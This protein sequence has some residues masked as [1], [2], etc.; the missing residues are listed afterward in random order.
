M[1]FWKLSPFL[2]LGFLLMYQ[3]GIFQAAPIRPA[4]E[5]HEYHMSLSDEESDLLLAE[6]V[7]SYMKSVAIEQEK[8]TEDAGF[9]VLKRACNTA[10]CLTHKLAGLLSQTGSVANT[11]L[12]PPDMVAKRPGRKA[13]DLDA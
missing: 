2:A 4:E 12:L 7:N 8:G 5:N 1:G 9:T 3:V 6:L 10:T 11:N 13:R